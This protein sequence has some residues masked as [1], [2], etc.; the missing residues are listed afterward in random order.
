MQI[1]FKKKSQNGKEKRLEGMTTFSF[2]ETKK[3]EAMLD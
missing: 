3:V 2:V 1:N